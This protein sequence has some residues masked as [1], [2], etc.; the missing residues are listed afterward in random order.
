MTHALSLF[1]WHG[2]S[3]CWPGSKQ[4]NVNYVTSSSDIRLYDFGQCFLVEFPWFCL[5][6]VKY[7]VTLSQAVFGIS[8]LM[9]L[10]YV[11][12]VIFSSPSKQRK[13]V[14][15]L[16]LYLIEISSLCNFLFYNTQLCS[17]QVVL[18]S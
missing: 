1:C 9:D 16:S 18:N 12:V 8:R 13:T 5:S 10:S 2:I 6:F 4:H 14:L 7:K 15:C 11:L 3:L 17:S